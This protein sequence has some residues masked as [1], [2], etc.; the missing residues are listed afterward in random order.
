MP[1]IHDNKSEDKWTHV[2]G[3][4]WL[5]KRDIDENSGCTRSE[6]IPECKN[7]HVGHATR[8]VID[9]D[10]KDISKEVKGWLK[11]YN[12]ASTKPYGYHILI[13]N[14]GP[15]VPSNKYNFVTSY[16]SAVEFYCG[17]WS[18]TAKWFGL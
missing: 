11:R 9:I 18:F 2:T 12:T 5:Y 16:G 1:C 15:F 6:R 17:L 10:C 14:T 4:D 13:N 7:K 8:Y 3:Q